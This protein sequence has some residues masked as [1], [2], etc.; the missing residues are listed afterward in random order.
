MFPTMLRRK[1]FRL[2]LPSRT[3][4]LGERTLIMGVLNITPDS[5]SDG[6]LYLAPDAAVLRA[7][8]IERAGA[9]I[10]DIGGES[11]R[12]G[13]Q[14]I[15]ADEEL[16]RVLPVLEAL[17]GRLKI[18][19]SIDTAKSEV[20]EAAAAAGA[21]ILNDVT[22]LRADP[23]LADV[24]RRRKLP[25]ILMHMR[26]E[27]RTMQRQPFARHILRDVT[28]ALRRAVSLAR[29]A[30]ISKS[31]L[32]L[33][34][35]LGFGKSYDQNFELLARLPELARLGFPLLVGAS[36]KSF[37]GRALAAAP[38]VAARKPL[39]ADAI[40]LAPE[41]ARIWGTAAAVAASVLAGAHIVRVHDVAEMSQVARVTDAILNARSLASRP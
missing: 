34:P 22:A 1:K 40:D 24:S 8:E 19:I 33:D 15:S 4:V 28:A 27:P 12:P 39:I 2:R 25:L 31:Q 5:F 10:L 9:D 35:G 32:I 17:R 14:P 37:I 21:E 7:L 16:R 3:L 23:C 6:G 13:S 29:R 26:G 41:S 38:G 30:G 18:P 20:A 11:T 36:R